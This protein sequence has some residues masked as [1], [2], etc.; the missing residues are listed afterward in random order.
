MDAHPVS[1]LANFL[2]Q[3]WG[4]NLLF[5][6]CSGGVG[7]AGGGIVHRRLLSVGEKFGGFI[8]VGGDVVVPIVPTRKANRG[9]A[10]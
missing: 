7:R 2:Y 3:R 6:K 1:S 5:R 8:F 9:A 4:I 10:F